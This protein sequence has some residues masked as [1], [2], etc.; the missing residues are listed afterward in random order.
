MQIFVRLKSAGKR[1]DVLSRA[2]YEIPDNTCSLRQLL[3]AMVRAETTRYR[4]RQTDEGLLRVLTAEAVEAQAAEG[5]VSFG[6]VYSDG[7]PDQEKAVADAIQA[8]EDGLVRVF[9][10]DN[11]ITELDCDA[12]FHPGAEITILRLTFLAGRMW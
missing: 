11:E 12:N 10:E 3:T 4:E 9:L 2:P 5:K 6:R 7:V 1:K 8:W